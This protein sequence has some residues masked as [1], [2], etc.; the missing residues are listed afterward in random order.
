[1]KYFTITFIFLI[2]FFCSKST[3]SFD[4]N[5]GEE[6]FLKY[7]ETKQ[8]QGENLSLKF[9]NIGDDSRCPLGTV[10]R[11]EGNFEIILKIFDQDFS[12]NTNLDPK[13]IY[14]NNFNIRLVSASPYPESNKIINKE[15]YTIQLVVTK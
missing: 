3:D 7:G 2:L 11:W 5:L 10:C 12:V 8:I 4:P 9:L 15:D 1:M 13:V 14:Y 6:F